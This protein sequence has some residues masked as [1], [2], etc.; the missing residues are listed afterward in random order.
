MAEREQKTHSGD[1]HHPAAKDP[2]DVEAD[3]DLVEIR[4]Q[5]T[6]RQRVRNSKCSIS[7]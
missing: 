4:E 6:F 7:Y 2:T 1:E 5:A 3:A